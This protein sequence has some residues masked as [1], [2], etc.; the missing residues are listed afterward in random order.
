MYNPILNLA[1]RIKRWKCNVCVTRNKNYF[2]FPFFFFLLCCCNTLYCLHDLC[3]VMA[4][5]LLLIS[6]SFAF[7]ILA[8]SCLCSSTIICFSP[9]TI[10]SLASTL[11]NSSFSLEYLQYK[12]MKKKKF[13][14]SLTWI[15]VLLSF[16]E[17]QTFLHHIC[18]ANL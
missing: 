15:P 18:S 6:S 13:G 5:L 14:R 10:A 8:S 2:F 1:F 17:D 12:K 11:S 4:A 9:S 16:D 7:L 3:R